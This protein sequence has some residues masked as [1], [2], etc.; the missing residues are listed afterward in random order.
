MIYA[1]L[2]RVFAYEILLFELQKNDIYLLL[3]G[4]IKVL[5]SFS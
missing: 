4:K 2:Y 1:I 3:R 5:A